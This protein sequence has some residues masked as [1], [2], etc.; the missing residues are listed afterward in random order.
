MISRA[1]GCLLGQL[2]GDAFGSLVELQAPQTSRR[3][4]RTES[5]I[6][7]MEVPGTPFGSADR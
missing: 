1:E 2:A 3:N 6:L 5:V 4:T 7:S